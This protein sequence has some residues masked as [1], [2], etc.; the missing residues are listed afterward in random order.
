MLP[1]S[2][3]WGGR[4]NR[5]EYGATSRFMASGC[6][7]ILWWLSYATPSSMYSTGWQ[8]NVTGCPLPGHQPALLH[9]TVSWVAWGAPRAPLP[10]LGCRLDRATATG[11]ARA[12]RGLWELRAVP[13]RTMGPVCGCKE[14]AEFQE[15]AVADMGGLGWTPSPGGRLATEQVDV[16]AGHSGSCEKQTSLPNL[17]ALP[18]SGCRSE[19][20]LLGDS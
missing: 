5:Q 20:D 18:S 4:K 3:D 19:P 11:Q 16:H 2:G 12:A 15:E 9:A 8:A 6:S 1:D 14:D 13:A 7:H 10:W 17:Q